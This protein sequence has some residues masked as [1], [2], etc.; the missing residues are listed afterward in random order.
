[1]A[2]CFL[3]H[4]GQLMHN[5]HQLS[6]HHWFRYW[7]VTWLAPSHYLHQCWNIVNWASRNKLRWNIS[8]NSCILIQENPFQNAIWKMV[9]ILFQ[10]QCVNWL[11]HI[12]ELGHQSLGYWLVLIPHQAMVNTDWVKGHFSTKPLSEPT[13][14]LLTIGP[15]HISH[16]SQW[17]YNNADGSCLV[18]YMMTSSNGNLFRVTGPLCGEFTGL[19]W[20]PRTK[21]SDA[22]LWC[23]LWSA[24]N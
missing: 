11:R 13:L 21:A 6:H 22:E 4:L 2:P 14:D 24:P 1:M 15:M 20:I 19:Q 5:M 9:A 12:C 3:T 23:F 8:G 7:L 17:Y 16:F 10:L 18:K